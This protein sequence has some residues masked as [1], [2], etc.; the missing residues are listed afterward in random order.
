MRSGTSL[1][2]MSIA[3]SALA[4]LTA[5]GRSGLWSMLRASTSKNALLSGNPT[6]IALESPAFPQVTL[7]PLKIR[8]QQVEPDKLGS[9]DW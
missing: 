7:V 2:S 6:L 1:L 8:V 3:A 4:A 5:S 9:K